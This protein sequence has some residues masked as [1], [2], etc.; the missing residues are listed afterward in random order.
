MFRVTKI[1]F[2]V[3]AVSNS[4]RIEKTKGRQTFE[5]LFPEISCGYRWLEHFSHCM[6]MICIAENACTNL[7]P[8]EICKAYDSAAKASMKRTANQL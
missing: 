1:I 6:N 3:K 5:R 7:K 8:N 2:I 4:Q